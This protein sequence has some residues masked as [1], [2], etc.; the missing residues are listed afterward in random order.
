MSSSASS[1]SPVFIFSAGWR[2][3]STMLQRILTASGNVLVWG[4]SGGALACM[5]DAMQKYMQMLGP[6][7]KKFRHGYGGNGAEQYQRFREDTSAGA[8]LWIASM[9]SGL[10]TIT[11]GFRGLL[12]TIYATPAAAM[13]FSRWGVKEVQLGLDNALF[14]RGIY[15][16]AKF[17]F[18]VRNPMASLLSIKRRDWMDRKGDSGALRYYAEHWLRL[19]SEFRR[20]DFGMLVQYE[21]LVK[22]R[23]VIAEIG[24]Y[25][26]LVGIPQDFIDKSHADWKPENSCYLSWLERRRILSIVGEEMQQHGYT[27]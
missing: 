20:A 13:G 9:N 16:D 25:L 21:K 15:P 1:N 3:G 7:G 26:G 2:T 27:A 10:D 17:I 4:E 8:K 18:I 23:S 6:G 12:D 19:A 11:D 24:D 22:D 5:D 14:L